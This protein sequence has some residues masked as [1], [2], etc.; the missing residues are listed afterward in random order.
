MRAPPGPPLAVA[1]MIL[2]GAAVAARAQHT[3]YALDGLRD[4][5]VT[6]DLATGAATDVGPIGFNAGFCGLAFN[7]VPVPGPGGSVFSPGT[8]FGVDANTQRLYTFDLGTGRAT[9]I[10]PTFLLGV[11]ETLTFDARGRLWTT[12]LY[13]RFTLDTA[14]GL[15]SHVPGGFNVPLGVAYS[16]DTLP[17]AVPAAGPG[18]LPAGTIIA[19]RAGLFHALDGRTWD[20]LLTTS[21]PEATEVVMAAPDGTIYA[22]GGPYESMSLYRLSLSPIGAELIGPT[23]LGHLWGGAIIPAPAGAMLVFG[24]IGACAARR[25]RASSRCPSCAALSDR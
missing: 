24:A 15:A 3:M 6:I 2:A 17:V 23:G 16:T 19:C 22:L 25:R 1:A 14:T 13:D 7:P 18:V 9:A 4:V 5:L 12:E 20:V 8:L 21:I 10:G 11:W